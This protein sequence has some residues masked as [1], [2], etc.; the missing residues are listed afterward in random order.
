MPEP[1]YTVE[2]HGNALTVWSDRPAAVTE[3]VVPCDGSI[4]L[5][6]SATGKICG[7]RIDNWSDWSEDQLADSFAT[8]FG[9][10][11]AGPLI[12]IRRALGKPLARV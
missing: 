2:F 12:A 1:E 11:G 9:W 4:M 10:G 3:S 5:R 7:K 6:D 8:A